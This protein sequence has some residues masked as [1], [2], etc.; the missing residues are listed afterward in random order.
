MYRNERNA[1]GR[2]IG[3][4]SL[5]AMGSLGVE[6]LRNA[7]Y[8]NSNVAQHSS[9]PGIWGERSY[10]DVADDRHKAASQERRSMLADLVKQTEVPRDGR[11][12]EPPEPIQE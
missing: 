8:P 6:E 12:P 11:E 9:E 10:G 4:Q 3:D 7:F 1:G 5:T 2:K